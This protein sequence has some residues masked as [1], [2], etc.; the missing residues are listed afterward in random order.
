MAFKVSSS[1]L[2]S[3]QP[4]GLLPSAFVHFTFR[5]EH[6]MRKLSRRRSSSTPYIA[7]TPQGDGW[8]RDIMAYLGG[9]NTGYVVIAAFRLYAL[10]RLSTDA[11]E[12]SAYMDVV[13]L[14]VLAFGNA[15][16]AVLNF[17]LS[18]RSG[19]WIMGTGLDRITVL[20]AFFAVLDGS[21]VA[22][23]VLGY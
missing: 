19:R 2:L 7:S 1:P 18:P 8:H 20:D 15:S 23:R 3:A 17:G 12:N 22:A 5:A 21:V 11:V 13:A 6:M 14:T 9:M 10:Y 16:Q 4:K